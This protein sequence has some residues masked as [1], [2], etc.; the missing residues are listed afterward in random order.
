MST[1]NECTHNCHT[2][3]SACEPDGQRK[4][5]FFDRMEAAS[6]AVSAMGEDN[7]IKMLEEA[8]ALLEAEDAAEALLEN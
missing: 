6:D 2:C 1:I 5:S 7:F 4:P 3:G 8:V